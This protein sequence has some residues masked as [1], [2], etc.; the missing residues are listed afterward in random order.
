M[1]L[2]EILARLTVVR[3]PVNGEYTCKCPAHDDKVAS[4]CVR[5]GDDGRILLHCHAR[6]SVQEVVKAM[7]LE[8]RDLYQ[9]EKPQGSSRKPKAEKKPARQTSPR[10]QQEQEEPQ[11]ALQVAK[12]LT[13]VYHYTDES[14]ADL[15]E[16]CRYEWTEQGLRKKTF[17]QRHYD[18]S[19]PAAK[20][21]GYVWE[22]RGIRSVLYRLPAVRRAI[23]A[24][25]PIY[26]VEGEKDADNLAALGLCA[27]TNPGGA[28]KRTPKWLPEHTAQL[29]GAKRIVILEDNDETG[30]GDRKQVAAWLAAEYEDVRLL[31]MTDIVPDL[32][33]HGDI[34]D[35]LERLGP[36]A[37]LEALKRLV[38]DTEPVSREEARS[39][40]L[41][42][43]AI[44]QIGQVS[45]YCVNDGCIAQ[46]QKDGIKRLCTFTA[47]VTEVLEQDDGVSVTK[48][49]RIDGWKANG[50]RLAPV[51]V[52][53]DAYKRMDWVE[54]AWDVSAT[55]LPGNSQRDKVRYVVMEANA[56]HVQRVTEY[57]HTGWRKVG[58][59]WCYLYEGGAVGT[60]DV[61]VKIQSGL[62]RYCLDT[63][64]DDRYEPGD[65]TMVSM[66]SD[67]IP[68]KISVPML[69]FTFLAPLRDA[70]H[71][72]GCAP[73]FLMFLRGGT[74]IGKSTISSLWLN[75][76]GRGFNEGEQVATYKD[77]MN[78]IR[79]KA[80]ILKDM[81]LAIDDYHPSGTIQD[82]RN[83]DGIAQ[84]LVRSFGDL[85]GRDRASAEGGLAGTPPPRCLGIT[86]GEDVPNVGESG[87]ARFYTID[88]RKGDINMS[89]ELLELQEMARRGGMAR[90]MRRYI[91]WLIPQM[92]ELPEKL[93]AKWLEYRR[94]VQSMKLSHA[95][96]PGAIA[97]LLLGYE[98][99]QE[100]LEQTGIVPGRDSA[101]KDADFRQAVADILTNAV[102]QS[103]ESVEERPTRMYLN[104]LRELLMT[105]QVY[106]E[107][108][109]STTG[110]NP[111]PRSVQIGYA[112]ASCYYLFPGPSYSAV[113][114]QYARRGVVF[115]LGE[116]SL[117]K[118]LRE[119]EMILPDAKGGKSTRVKEIGGKKMRYLW[120]PREKIDGVDE[121][122]PTQMW[123][124]E[125]DD[126]ENPFKA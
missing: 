43:S 69:G 46:Y 102:A 91:E 76:F 44:G 81:V 27:T 79:K 95:R 29:K 62:E 51:N 55:I 70:L 75:F 48:Y 66:L 116:R 83:M 99:Y 93:R 17:L 61:R 59:K 38:D 45:G 18:P 94:L 50:R 34:S 124:Q 96:A 126:G 90:M 84:M 88:L 119:D 31:S 110:G 112:D 37:T 87:F 89:D 10:K 15:F 20:A 104:T 36:E 19:D 92:D 4:L 111:P 11:Q 68:R 86:S 72:A 13:K 117:Y 122:K 65:M 40:Q 54:A 74:G 9:D 6:C 28:N 118:Q 71:R 114:E 108:L 113:Y 2:S 39:E 47:M 16:V 33:E 14:G 1:Q 25:E 22:T 60:D 7:G 73:A 85:A 78:S 106:V 32:Q 23:D 3:G 109:G 120:V 26:I 67:V 8:M 107:T 121:A 5:E 42:K 105:K 123:L 53:A 98:M 97:H 101:W 77:T 56:D 82:K 12:K 35:V 63:G 80:F 58:R 21:D 41:R 64:Y 125:E 24:G 30:V 49:L 115:P 100:F 103:T 52:K 57:T